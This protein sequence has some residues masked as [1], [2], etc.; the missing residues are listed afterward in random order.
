MTHKEF[1]LIK[2]NSI[3]PYKLHKTNENENSSYSDLLEVQIQ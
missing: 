2:K 3:Q 1:I